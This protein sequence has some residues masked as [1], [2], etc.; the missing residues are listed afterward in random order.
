MFAWL[1]TR[2]VLYC[3]VLYD[4]RQQSHVEHAFTIHIHYVFVPGDNH[5][6]SIF[7]VIIFDND[8]TVID[9]PHSLDD[10]LISKLPNDHCRCI[11]II[12]E[13]RVD[14]TCF[15]FYDWLM[16][17]DGFCAKSFLHVHM[18]LPFSTGSKNI[19]RLFTH[20]P[21]FYYIRQR[22][23]REQALLKSIPRERYDNTSLWLDIGLTDWLTDWLVQQK[24]P[25][26]TDVTW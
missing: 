5:H 26:R 14:M 15:M 1:T 12:V 24:R 8:T 17:F 19:I 23:G 16:D 10:W 13:G 3:T 7:H 18:L 6:S 22:A 4:H 20:T 11:W 21:L 25:V 2:S 9:W